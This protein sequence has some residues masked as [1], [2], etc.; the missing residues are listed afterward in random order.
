MRKED[1]LPCVTAWM[2]LEHIMLSKKTKTEKDKYCMIAFICAIYQKQTCKKKSKM[3]VILLGDWGGGD[4]SMV[5]KCT[6]L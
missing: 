4:K 3:V 5:I 2:D 6:N 1:I